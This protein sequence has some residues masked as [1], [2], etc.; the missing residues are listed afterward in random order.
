MSTGTATP[1]ELVVYAA[2]ADED[3]VDELVAASCELGS[4]TRPLGPDRVEIRVYFAEGSS[5]AAERLRATLVTAGCDVGGLQ[6]VAATDWLASYRAQ[7]RPF[8]V[9][10]RWWI[11]PAPDHATPAPAGRD[12]LVLE[13]RRAFGTG[14]HPS[15]RLMLEW[16]E[17]RRLD[18][19]D[20]LD[21]GSG[22][23]VLALAGECRG[24]DFV[25][26]VDVDHEAVFVAREVA[27]QQEWPV[28]VA[29]VAGT[30][31]VLVPARTFDVVLCNMISSRLVPLLP[32]LGGR[33]RAGGRLV[34][35]GILDEETGPAGRAIA[36]LGGTT[37]TGTWSDSGWAC[38][39]ASRE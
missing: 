21:V 9:G 19:C 16:L 15:T 17:G 11:D 10:R 22:S 32:A 24:A 6:P 27:A 12:R 39:E 26:A 1:L 18:G 4:W 7:A 36:A 8:A 2:A 31:D 35:A 37:V 20:L 28:R 34:V 30:I 3:R 33:L 13:P 23:G 38:L 5:A 14:T 25:V 29:L